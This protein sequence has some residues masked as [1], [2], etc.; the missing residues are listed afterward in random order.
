MLGPVAVIDVRHVYGHRAVEEHG[1]VRDLPSPLEPVNRVQ[2]RL[3]A[4]HGER[5]R[6]DRPTACCRASD[7][8]AQRRLGVSLLVQTVPIG[9]LDHDCVRSFDCKRR[10]HDRI[11][12]PAEIPGE[13]DGGITG[14]EL[15][16]SSAE[17]MACL[18]ETHADT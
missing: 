14:G 10:P 11:V 3:G 12:G 4:T 15:D 18:P 5:G 2:Q 1:K 17:D 13:Q 7:D 9:C 16:R 6:D 8:F